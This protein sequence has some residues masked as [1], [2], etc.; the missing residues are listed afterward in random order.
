MQLEELCTLLRTVAETGVQSFSY[1]E[2]G[3]R[4]AIQGKQKETVQ[5][6]Q[7]DSKEMIPAQNGIPLTAVSAV[8]SKETKEAEDSAVE[9]PSPLVG[10]F[11]A[12]PAEDA[13]PYVKVGDTVKAGQTI[14]IVEAMKLMNEI[15]AETDG[16]ITEILVENAQAVEFGQPLFKIRKA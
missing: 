3:V 2:N 10:I 5:I 9:I 12:A 15:E 6:L 16:V 7:T 14:A 11:Y 13:A 8:P 1:E 4:V